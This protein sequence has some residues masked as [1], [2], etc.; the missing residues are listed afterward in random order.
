MCYTVLFTDRIHAT[1]M[2]FTEHSFNTDTNKHRVDRTG[3]DLCDIWRVSNPSKEVMPPQASP[4]VDRAG[5]VEAMN[6]YLP[7]PIENSPSAQRQNLPKV[8]CVLVGDGTIGK[9]SLVVSYTT[10]GY[11]TEYVPTAFD[12]YSGNRACPNFMFTQL[13]FKLI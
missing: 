6:T 3:R 4:V 9:T 7:E 2:V 10:N 8:K 12:N 5:R 1:L 11:P 13:H